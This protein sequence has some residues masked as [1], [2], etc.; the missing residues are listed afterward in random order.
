M[1][2][3]FIFYFSS[4][5]TSS[6]SAIICPR[7]LW[8]EYKTVVDG[9]WSFMIERD[10][11]EPVLQWTIRRETQYQCWSDNDVEFHTT[12]QGYTRANQWVLD[13]YNF[14][15]SFS[16]VCKEECDS[17]NVTVLTGYRHR[18]FRTRL[19]LAG[20]LLT[21]IKTA[22]NFIGQIGLKV[23]TAVYHVI[24]IILDTARTATGTE[25]TKNI[26]M[27]ISQCRKTASQSGVYGLKDLALLFDATQ[28]LGSE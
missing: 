15:Q 13:K 1:I 14:Y 17:Q 25:S 12:H 9:P 24:E 23:Q 7:Y 5:I 27:E 6:R 21:C 4:L 28:R 10:H 26:A 18:Y 22:T 11:N 20:S 16:E 3:K 8:T 19:Q 2:V